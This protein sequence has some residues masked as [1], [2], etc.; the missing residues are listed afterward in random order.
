M[1]CDVG[2]S[3][4]ECLDLGL[5]DRMVD[6]HGQ[7]GRWLQSVGIGGRSLRGRIRAVCAS[8]SRFD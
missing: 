8:P 2:R 4:G 1:G 5:C 3:S 6:G 7:C